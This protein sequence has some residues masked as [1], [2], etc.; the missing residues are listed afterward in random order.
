MGEDRGDA[1]V[2]IGTV[3]GHTV[4]GDGWSTQEPSVGLL[5]VWLGAGMIRDVIKESSNTYVLVQRIS[6]TRG[7]CWKAVVTTLSLNPSCSRSDEQPARTAW[8]AASIVSSE[9]GWL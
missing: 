4:N 2:S 5:R 7:Y 1:E 3:V 8:A 6:R 9:H